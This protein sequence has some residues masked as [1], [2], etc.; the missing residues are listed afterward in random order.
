MYEVMCQTPSD[1]YE[2]LPTLAKYASECTHIT[3]CG[4]GM[5]YSSFALAHGLR[6]KPEARLV[7]VDVKSSPEGQTFQEVCIEDGLDTVFHQM[8]DLDCP[9]EETD[10]LFIDTWHIYG[11]L[12]REL[13][14]WHSHVRKYIILHDTVVD[15]LYGETIRMKKDAA[16]QSRLSG[17]PVDEIN[18]GLVYAVNE[19]LREHPEWVVHAHFTNNNGLTVLTRYIPV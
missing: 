1:I 19:F 16:E 9:I 6:D 7:Q 13:A 5:T 17:I 2:H 15:G 10:L 12:K 18:K 8:S 11:H 14:R 4:V 3:E